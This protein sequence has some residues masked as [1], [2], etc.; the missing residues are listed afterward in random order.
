MKEFR[1]LKLVD[2]RDNK[3]ER[4][5]GNAGADGRGGVLSSSHMI[6]WRSS[7]PTFT[8]G[9]H[10]HDRNHDKFVPNHFRRGFLAKPKSVDSR[11]FTIGSDKSS[12]ITGGMS[13]RNTPRS[14]ISINKLQPRPKSAPEYTRKV[15]YN[16]GLPRYM[17]GRQSVQV[18]RSSSVPIPRQTAKARTH[19]I[20]NGTMNYT[21]CSSEKTSEFGGSTQSFDPNAS[22]SRGLTPEDIAPW[23]Q[24]SSQGIPTP[25]AF[26]SP[27]QPNINFNYWKGSNVS[28]IEDYSP[29]KPEY[30]A[31]RKKPRARSHFPRS[32]QTSHRRMTALVPLVGKKPQPAVLK[33]AA[34]RRE[35]TRRLKSRLKA[36]YEL[37]IKC[38]ST[39][40]CARSIQELQGHRSLLKVV[41]KPKSPPIPKVKEKEQTKWNCFMTEMTETLLNLK[42]QKVC[43]FLIFKGL[44]KV[45]FSK[46][47]DHALNSKWSWN[48]R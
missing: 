32:R 6:T 44:Q 40:R 12:K 22:V 39:D 2:L 34:K 43:R 9:E 23:D 24:D 45:L 42:G 17:Q 15:S 30:Q 4:S 29:Y 28:T 27:H 11:R 20:K 37:P 8:S 21:G 26:E 33:E 7:K 16:K 47:V 5:S 38:Q 25:L 36:S 13:V 19:T 41:T 35:R 10:P 18:S 31:V 3:D 48:F 14:V 46:W 1:I